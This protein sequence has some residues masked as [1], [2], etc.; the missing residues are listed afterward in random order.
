MS[1]KVTIQI[2]KVVLDKADGY[3]TVTAEPTGKS[4]AARFE[5]AFVHSRG[6]NQ[7]WMLVN[8]ETGEIEEEHHDE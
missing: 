5:D 7:S 3:V 4:T 8:A 6:P 1:E 2:P